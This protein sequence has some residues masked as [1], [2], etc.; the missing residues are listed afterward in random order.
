MERGRLH[1]Q[2]VTAKWRR[3]LADA[4]TVEVIDLQD[5]LRR[6]GDRERQL[7]ELRRLCYLVVKA[8]HSTDH[9]WFDDWCWDL[10]CGLLTGGYFDLWRGQPR[11][12]WRLWLQ[13]RLY[14]LEKPEHRLAEIREQLELLDA[15]HA[16]TLP[17]HDPTGVGLRFLDGEARAKFRSGELAVLCIDHDDTSVSAALWEALDRV[18]GE[19]DPDTLIAS[20]GALCAIADSGRHEAVRTYGKAEKQIPGAQKGKSQDARRPET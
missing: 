4:E 13:L 16:G 17:D 7:V 20:Y 9:P 8:R 12:K 14:E 3:G 5:S 2:T 6:E 18:L 15:P 10:L 11:A 1:R 19:G